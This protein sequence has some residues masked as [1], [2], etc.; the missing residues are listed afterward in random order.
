MAPDAD[1]GCG[2]NEAEMGAAADVGEEGFERFVE[3]LPGSFGLVD[4][5]ASRYRAGP[6]SEV[7]ESKGSQMV[8]NLVCD[9]IGAG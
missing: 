5:S 6:A 2:L 7:L 3:Q 8:G 4:I 9:C 1:R